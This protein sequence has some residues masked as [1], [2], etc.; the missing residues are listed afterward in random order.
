VRCT[1]C[2]V[3]QVRE[4]DDVATGGGARSDL[5]ARSLGEAECQCRLRESPIGRVVY[6]DGTLPTALPVSYSLVGSVVMFHLDAEWGT[7]HAVVDQL[8][9][10]EVDDYDSESRTGWTILVRGRCRRIDDHADHWVPSVE[11]LVPGDDGVVV[12]LD[13]DGIVGRQIEPVTFPPGALEPTR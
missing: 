6:L 1:P 3:R 9:A 4:T 11:R 7:V 2:V 8:A 12:G 13:V 10:F 5:V